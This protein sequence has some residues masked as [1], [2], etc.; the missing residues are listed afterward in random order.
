MTA[1]TTVTRNVS[2]AFKE[3][4]VALMALKEAQEYVAEA[5][6]NAREK[7]TTANRAT[8]LNPEAFR[9]LACGRLE[10][11]EHALTFDNH[12]MMHWEERPHTVRRF[13]L[14]AISHAAGEEA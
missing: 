10:L 14:E 3:L 8:R 5:E 12:C 13:Q 6:R 9:L 11:T 4:D 7:A 2:Q 1:T